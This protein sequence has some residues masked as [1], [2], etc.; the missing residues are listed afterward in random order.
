MSQHRATE[1]EPISRASANLPLWIITV[2]FA[3]TAV[4]GVIAD[5]LAT[6]IGFAVA[7]AAAGLAARLGAGER[8]GRRW[9]DQPV[10]RQFAIPLAA[11]ALIVVTL[12]V[13]GFVVAGS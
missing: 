3:G 2:L 1:D 13:V 9:N 12:I 5:S 10:G 6:A 8:L 7:A 11:L 4:A